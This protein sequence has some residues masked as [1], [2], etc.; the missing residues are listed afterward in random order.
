[1]ILIVP[2]SPFEITVVYLPPFALISVF[3][4]SIIPEPELLIELVKSPELVCILLSSTVTFDVLVLDNTPVINELVIVTSPLPFTETNPQFEF[5][6]F[7]FE[8]SRT[9]TPDILPLAST[10]FILAPFSP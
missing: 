5:S 3:I 10:I 8:V 6:I 9:S 2:D 1:M 4:V 7:S